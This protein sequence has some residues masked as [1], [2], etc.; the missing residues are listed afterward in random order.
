[1]PTANGAYTT[2]TYDLVSGSGSLV[3]GRSLNLNFSG[4]TY[5]DGTDVLQLFANKGGLSGNFSAVNFAGLAAGR[6]ATFNPAT[7]FI[8]LVPEPSTVAP[9]VTRL[10]FGC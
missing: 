2:G 1:M 9:L 10:V 3:F 6:S 7:G 4:G 8:S 5:P